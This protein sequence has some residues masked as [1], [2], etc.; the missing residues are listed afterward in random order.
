MKSRNMI[1]CAGVEFCLWPTKMFCVCWEKFYGPSDFE[2][3]YL[4]FVSPTLWLAVRRTVR[5]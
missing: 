2:R 3:E 1:M 4:R 5:V